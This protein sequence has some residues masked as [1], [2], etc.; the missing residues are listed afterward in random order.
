MRDLLMVEVEANAP[1]EIRTVYVHLVYTHHNI[2]IPF[3]VLCE[4]TIT[5]HNGITF[6]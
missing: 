1:L 4:Q 5:E 6:R 2:A 3:H